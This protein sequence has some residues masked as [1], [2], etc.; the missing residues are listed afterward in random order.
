ML[1]LDLSKETSWLTNLRRVLFE[2]AP[3]HRFLN[4]LRSPFDLS[5]NKCSCGWH[6][7]KACFGPMPTR[8]HLVVRFRLQ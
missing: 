7:A 3:R 6:A 1:A 4:K 8:S 2:S 5:I